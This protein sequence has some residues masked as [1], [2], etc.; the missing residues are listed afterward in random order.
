MAKRTNHRNPKGKTHGTT[1]T[2]RNHARRLA[3][4]EHKLN[5]LIALVAR[6][7]A[8]DVGPSNATSR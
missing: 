7:N 2:M 4:L 3:A 1:S 6:M 8:P 5:E